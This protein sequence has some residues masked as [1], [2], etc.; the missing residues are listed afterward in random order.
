MVR[1]RK[2][3][4]VRSARKAPRSHSKP[5]NTVHVNTTATTQ[6]GGVS[7]ASAVT[8]L[9]E[10]STSNSGIW[11]L[12]NQISSL[13]DMF[14]LFRINDIRFEFLPQQLTSSVATNIPSGQ[15]SIKLFGQNA[16]TTF[17]DLEGP[18]VSNMTLPYG[19][20][21]TAIAEGLLRECVAML[22]VKN[23]DLAILEGP[24]DPADLGYLA[25]QDDG[26]QTSFG[27]LFWTLMTATAANTLSYVLRTYLD[28]DFKDILDPATISAEQAARAQA[29][30]AFHVNQ[31]VY[32][33]TMGLQFSPGTLENAVVLHMKAPR[34]LSTQ[35][36]QGC[37]C[38]NCI[39]TNWRTAKAIVRSTPQ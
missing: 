8:N 14:R 32:H 36:V 34:P 20:S 15:L 19:T 29:A 37:Q 38:D 23:G 39:N 11:N 33:P 16:P 6:Y 31:A 2:N 3:H 1:E 4:K 26:T 27:T 9:G 28:L 25:T 24:S 12:N 17:N 18:L 30:V 10:L 7:T 22:H 13:S 21:N 5:Q 35:H